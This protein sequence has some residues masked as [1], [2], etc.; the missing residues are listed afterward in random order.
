[1]KVGAGNATINFTEELLPIEGFIGI[2][3]MPKLSVV[4]IDNNDTK[5]VVVSIEIVML[6][7]DFIERCRKTISNILD[8]SYENVW[9]HVTHAITTPHA[10]GGPVLGLGGNEVE[11]SENEKKKRKY[12]LEK[13]KIYEKT[14]YN[15]LIEALVKAS[16]LREAVMLVGT[17]E[18]GLI[19]NRDIE[20]PEGWWIGVDSSHPIKDKMSI[21]SFKD[22]EGGY[23]ANLIFYGMKP[24]VI[25]NAEMEKGT[26]LISADAPGL[27]CRLL[28]KQYNSPVLYFTGAAGNTVPIKTAWFDHIGADG[29]L[30]TVDFGVKRGLEYANEI[31]TELAIKA[32]DIINNSR[33]DD[34][35]NISIKQTTFVWQTKD[36]VPMKPYKDIEY[37]PEGEKKIPVGVLKLGET[38]LVAGKPEIN[39][40]TEQQMQKI[41]GYANVT[42]VSMVNGGMKYMPDKNSYAEVHWEAI[43]SMLMPGAAEKFVDEAIK[44]MEEE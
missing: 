40:V 18:C 1:M 15:A 28:E 34:S 41:S 14:I 31:A 36:R 5:V 38:V 22:D 2:H 3:D 43:A 44:L 35:N 37:I 30:M 32:I 33:V 17:G 26:R 42:Y 23:I 24:C 10:P 4:F 13:R 27:M 8:V 19:C 9:L 16:N 20:T 29:K 11:I 25:D 7:D 39:Y 12:E 21:I 6:W